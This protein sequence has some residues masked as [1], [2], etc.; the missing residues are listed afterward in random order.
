MNNLIIPKQNK[1]NDTEEV[2]LPMVKCSFC[3]NM[4]VTGMHQI[5]LKMVK[6]G[7]MKIE[8]GK[9]LYKPSVNKRI[10]YYMCT[11]CIKSGKHWPGQRP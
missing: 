10:D 7:E 8:N 4:T 11:N 5:R 1:I 3:H 9:R 2:A 6:K